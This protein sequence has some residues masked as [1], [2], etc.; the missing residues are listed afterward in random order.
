MATFIGLLEGVRVNE[1]IVTEKLGGALKAKAAAKAPRLR[2]FFFGDRYI[3][4]FLPLFSKQLSHK[5]AAAIYL[6][7]PCL[8]FSFVISDRIY[9]LELG[10]GA[11]L[12]SCGCYDVLFG[13][14]HYFIYLF[15]QALA[16]FIM[17]FGYVGIYVPHT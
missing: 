11:F 7:Q 2:R 5:L 10:V 12:F 16:F 4:L 17:G 15:V 3:I 1:W 6:T 14:N 8:T 9:L 13:N